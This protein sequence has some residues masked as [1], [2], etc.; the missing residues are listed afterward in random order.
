M[1][2]QLDIG[3]IHFNDATHEINDIVSTYFDIKMFLNCC[4]I[5]MLH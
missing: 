5:F 3:E 2:K 1:K 4:F